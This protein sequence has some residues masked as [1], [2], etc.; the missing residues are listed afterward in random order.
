MATVEH[1]LE[2]WRALNAQALEAEMLVRRAFE[3]Q[4]SGGNGPSLEMIRTASQ[5]R[6]DA[7]AALSRLTESV[8]G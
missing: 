3:D 5:L 4:L 6:E 8:D 7:T 2:A 1:L